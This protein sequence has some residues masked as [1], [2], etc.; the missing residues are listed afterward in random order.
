MRFDNYKFL[1]H[2]C[3]FL[4][5]NN[6]SPT[7]VVVVVVGTGGGQGG[8]GGNKVAQLKVKKKTTNIQIKHS[9]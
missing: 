7:V 9:L 2:F 1:N 3:I 5:L 8:Q 4:K 6:F